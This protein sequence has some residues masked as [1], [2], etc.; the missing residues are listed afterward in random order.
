M[1]RYIYATHGFPKE[2]LFTLVRLINGNN[3]HKDRVP[4]RL[5]GI[6]QH[7]VDEKGIISIEE[8]EIETDGEHIP[9]DKL[10]EIGAIMGI[11]SPLPKFLEEWDK[12]KVKLDEEVDATA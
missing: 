5:I 3:M 1:K 12:S 11:V 2:E 4:I 7:P 10:E 6:I 8:Y 9:L